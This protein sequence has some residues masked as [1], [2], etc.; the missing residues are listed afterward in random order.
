MV[1][2]RYVAERF[3]ETYIKVGEEIVGR[4][5]PTGRGYKYTSDHLQLTKGSIGYAFYEVYWQNISNHVLITESYRQ[6]SINPEKHMKDIIG[7][8]PVKIFDGTSIEQANKE[9]LEILIK[10]LVPRNRQIGE[11][12]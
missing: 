10:K 1:T 7:P 6:R 5:K 4:I 12:G 9:C 11:Q 2:A 8:T 3:E